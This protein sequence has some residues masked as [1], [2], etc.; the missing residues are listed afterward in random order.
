MDEI[1]SLFKERARIHILVYGKVQGVFF[2]DYTKKEADKLGL[3]GWVKNI[4]DAVEIIAEGDKTKLREFILNCQK[5]NPLSK[6][7]KTDYKWE[8]YTGKFD[9]FFINY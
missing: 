9:R 1:Q 6:V 3:T 2:R 8:E 7:E 5:G 4:D